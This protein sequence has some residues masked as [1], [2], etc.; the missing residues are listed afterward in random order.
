MSYQRPDLDDYQY[1]AHGL[2]VAGL[3]MIVGMMRM[4]LDAAAFGM[5][6]LI[7]LGV[8]LALVAVLVVQ[9]HLWRDQVARAVV[10]VGNPRLPIGFTLAV[11]IYI[12]GLAGAA[13]VLY[14]VFGSR[15]SG[16]FA[17]ALIIGMVAGA[18]L[19]WVVLNWPMQEIR[20]RADEL[21]RE[22]DRRK[23][24][25]QARSSKGDDDGDQAGRSADRRR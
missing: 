22:R 11:A 14:E 21:Y 20:N 8:G 23:F 19:P 9:M 12:L 16:D 25:R 4:R 3:L 1:L 5:G 13:V 15:G 2:P 24:G 6:L 10:E 18:F 17:I 7:G